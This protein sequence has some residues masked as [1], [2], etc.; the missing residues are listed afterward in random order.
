MKE[1]TNQIEQSNKSSRKKYGQW[2]SFLM[3]FFNK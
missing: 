2:A 3:K 1:E